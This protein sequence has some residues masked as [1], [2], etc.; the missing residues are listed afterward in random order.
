[1]LTKRKKTRVINNTKAHETDTGGVT[2][3][4]G[5][6]S[7]RIDELATHLK[8]NPKD[9]HSRRGLLQIVASRQSHMGYLK[10]KSTR[11]YNSLMKTLNLKQRA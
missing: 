6:L 5:L 1:M 9:I 2:V 4:I 11:R 7:K 8:K 10:K 3:Q